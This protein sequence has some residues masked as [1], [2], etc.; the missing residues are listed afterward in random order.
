M[1]CGDMPAGSKLTLY[2]VSGETVAELPEVGYRAEWDGK[3]EGGRWAA[4]GIYY[5][6]VRLG[7]VVLLKTVLVIRGFP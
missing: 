3:T 6:V 4:P 2:T 7:N 1:K 5:A